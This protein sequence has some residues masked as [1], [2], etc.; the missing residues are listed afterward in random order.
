M[1]DFLNTLVIWAFKLR[2]AT[3]MHLSIIVH[4]QPLARRNVSETSIIMLSRPLEGTG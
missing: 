1:V 3:Q 2:I 4:L